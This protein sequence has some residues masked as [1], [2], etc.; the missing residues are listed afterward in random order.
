VK[1]RRLI[2]NLIYM[3]IS[4]FK[5]LLEGEE[6]RNLEILSPYYVKV[7]YTC[8]FI[9]SSKQSYEVKIQFSSVAQWC[10]TLCDPMKFSHFTDEENMT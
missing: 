7:L 2:I 4:I 5:S 9:Y 6:R 10:P 8:Y 3:N 1:V